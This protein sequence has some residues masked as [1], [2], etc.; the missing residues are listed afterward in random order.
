MRSRTAVVLSGL[1][2]F[3]GFAYLSACTPRGGGGG[4][5]GGGGTGGN[6]GTGSTGMTGDTGGGGGGT[7]L[8]AVKTGIPLRFDQG[9]KAGDDLIVFGINVGKGIQY[10]EPSKGPT[11]GTDFS[12][13]ADADATH[14]A[15]TG[16]NIVMVGGDGTT[17]SVSVYNVATGTLTTF[18]ETDLRAKNL[19]V[20]DDERGPVHADGDYAVVANDPSDVDGGVNL[21]LI[22]LKGATPTLVPLANIDGVT[23]FSSFGLSSA[24][25]HAASMKVVGELMNIFYVWDI[26]NPD[27]APMTFDRSDK[28]VGDAKWSFN[29]TYIFYQ[30]GQSDESPTL[31]DVTDGSSKTVTPNPM[32]GSLII[33]GD[34]LA[35]LLS[36]DTFDGFSNS[37][38]T[39]IGTVA[40]TAT[41]QGPA[42]DTRGNDEP[43]EGFVLE[44]SATP[45]GMYIF[46]SGD[47]GITLNVER[48]HVSRNGGTFAPIADGADDFLQ[49]SDVDASSNT[50][51]FK[52]GVNN[53]LTL[54][55]IIL[56]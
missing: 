43:A 18:P 35:Y 10:V 22:D 36:R 55:Y 24:F 25:V 7:G 28:G 19:P 51:G 32:D 29:G 45:D 6:G 48:L 9:L 31:L 26:N 8:T 47:A 54:A 1:A 30:D 5:G 3:V 21:T 4:G 49:A 17:F 27:T 13:S 34:N 12:G 50:V 16:K 37:V 46:G 53:D 41:A 15:V 20:E 11:A 44:F 2:I 39:A 40:G 42:G 23:E 56:P 33:A 14:F 52:T 38:R